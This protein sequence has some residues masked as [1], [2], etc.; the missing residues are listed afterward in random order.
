MFLVLTIRA[1]KVILVQV[2]HFPTAGRPGKKMPEMSKYRLLE[3]CIN[4]E[5]R[6]N[7]EAFFSSQC[8]Q[9]C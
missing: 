9:C 3:G 5:S 6:K 8:K 2:P 7:T 4:T 1:L